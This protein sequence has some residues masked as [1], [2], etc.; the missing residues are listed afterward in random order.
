MTPSTLRARA[1]LALSLAISISVILGWIFEIAPMVKWSP[2]G[3]APEQFATAIMAILLTLS[4][5]FARIREVAAYCAGALAAL[6]GLNYLGALHWDVSLFLWP[7]PFMGQANLPPSRPS[8]NTSV[9]ALIAV[10]AIAM[11]RRFALVADALCS[12][13]LTICGSAAMGYLV[14]IDGF[15]G[16]EGLTDMAASTALSYGLIFAALVW[17]AK[18]EPTRPLAWWPTLVFVNGWVMA[19]IVWYA[20]KDGD[21]GSETLAEHVDI[22]AALSCVVFATLAALALRLKLGLRESEREIEERLSVVAIAKRV[23][24]GARDRD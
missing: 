8:P 12:L 10:V 23:K 14:L 15:V 20:L 4:I 11:Q 7:D 9:A 1:A 24:E 17:S 6:I 18:K 3:N 19:L 16:F 13:G 22:F 5:G 21:G 2:I